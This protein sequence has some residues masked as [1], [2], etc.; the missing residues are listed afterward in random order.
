VRGC[1]FFVGNTPGL[2]AA[3]TRARREVRIFINDDYGGMPDIL[4]GA[5]ENGLISVEKGRDA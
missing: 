3:I 1:A 4:Q 5:A 2:D